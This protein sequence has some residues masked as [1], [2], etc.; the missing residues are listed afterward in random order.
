M[1]AG[2]FLAMVSACAVLATAAAA[3][4]HAG[5]SP[6]RHGAV[7]HDALPDAIAF[8]MRSWG[9]LVSQWSVQRD[10]QGFWIGT[11]RNAPVV[12]ARVTAK[13]DLAMGA[14]A[15]GEIAQILAALPDPAPDAA[16]CG[17]FMTDQ[18]YG[19]VRV[20]RGATTTEIA[21]NAGCG[22]ANYVA[23]LDVL[24]AADARMAQEGRKSPVIPD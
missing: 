1:K 4:D 7:A 3:S 23:M 19:T 17:A 15:F 6:A 24:K 18:S 9:T 21:W 5:A 12:G 10:G 16:K 14:K 11:A 20:T 13:H 8:E 2:R 22:D